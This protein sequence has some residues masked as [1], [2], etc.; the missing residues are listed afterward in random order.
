MPI[1]MLEASTGSMIVKES[2]QWYLAILIYLLDFMYMPTYD[3]MEVHI[4]SEKVRV[5]ELGLNIQMKLNHQKTN[6][7][8]W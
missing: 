5:I 6:L 8:Y 7:V 4:I 3:Q 1:A 2:Q